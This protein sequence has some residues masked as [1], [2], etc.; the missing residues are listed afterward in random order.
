MAVKR[1]P[2]VAREAWLPLA[3]VTVFAAFI[4]LRCGAPWAVLA[5]AGVGLAYYLARDPQRHTPALPLGIV[6]PVDG[7]VVAVEACQ[8]P[9]RERAA[10][11]IALNMSFWDVYSFYAPLEGKLVDQWHRRLASNGR[12][13]VIFVIRTDEGDE[14][15]MEISTGA[16]AGPFSCNYLPGERVGHGHRLGFTYFGSRVRLFVPSG[17]TLQASL[18]DRVV[19]ATTVVATL[20]RD[21]LAN[22]TGVVVTETEIA[23]E[24]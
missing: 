3:G 13:A 24:R 5:W 17:S 7:K 10:W 14:I 16:V 22:A 11:C 9:W 18:C 12:R 21:Q 2:Y 15:T 20:V 8:D 6:S 19:A 23:G 1:T 4:T